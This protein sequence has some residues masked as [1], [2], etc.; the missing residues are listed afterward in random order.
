MR[1][2]MAVAMIVIVIASMIV[3]VLVLVIVRVGV[4]GKTVCGGVHVWGA[5]ALASFRV[6]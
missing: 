3:L 2:G 5:H 1:V 4:A 6:W